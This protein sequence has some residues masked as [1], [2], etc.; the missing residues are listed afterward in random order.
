M[1]PWMRHTA[2]RDAW[3]TGTMDGSHGTRKVIWHNEGVDK[4]HDSH[5]AYAVAEYVLAKGIGYHLLWDSIHDIVIQL[6]PATGSARSL[7]NP[8][9]LPWSPNKQGEI[10]LQI[11]VVGFG[12]QSFTNGPLAGAARIMRY[13]DSLKIPRWNRGFTRPG[14]S[15]RLWIKS[16]HHGHCHAPGNDHTDPGNISIKRLW[17]AAERGN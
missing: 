11:C 8:G 9:D 3:G 13:V 1:T 16:G 14:R 12:S 4:P 2:R 6:H 7:F 15:Q 5:D 10:A 17:G